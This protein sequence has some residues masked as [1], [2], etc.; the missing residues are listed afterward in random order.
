MHRV[1]HDLCLFAAR[2]VLKV[3]NNH[4]IIFDY[5]EMA[6]IKKFN[7]ALDQAGEDNGF[8]SSYSGSEEDEAESPLK[9]RE[10]ISQPKSTI[11]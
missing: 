3:V 5:Q 1:D 11:S 10:S 9:V 4:Q 2:T 7:R 6:I 8:H